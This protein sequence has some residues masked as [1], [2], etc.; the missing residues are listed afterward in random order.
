ML[1]GTASRLEE[2]DESLDVLDIDLYAPLGPARVEPGLK[3]LLKYNIRRKRWRGW[4]KKAP[5][6]KRIPT[7]VFWQ[8]SDYGRS[9]GRVIGTLIVASHNSLR[10][11]IK[12]VEKISDKDIINVEIAYGGLIKYEL[13]ES[14]K[15][16]NKKIL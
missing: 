12:H 2:P 16:K 6:W 15:L 4:Y 13:D 11:I 7:K 8:M 14:L 1:I 3:Q 5:W 10:A 9:T